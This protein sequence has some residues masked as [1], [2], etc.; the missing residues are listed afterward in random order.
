MILSRF[1]ILII[2]C[3]IAENRIYVKVT[4][5]F[6]QIVKL[7]TNKKGTLT[8]SFKLVPWARLELALGL[9]LIGF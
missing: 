3:K 7:H 5:Y 8:S 4:V 9:T 6:S 2:L 1:Q